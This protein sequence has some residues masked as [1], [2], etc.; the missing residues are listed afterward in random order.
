MRKIGFVLALL[1]AFSMTVVPVVPS[2]AAQPEQK[3]TEQKM[4]SHAKRGDIVVLSQEQMASLATSH[5]A[6]HSKLSEAN[7]KGTLPKLTAAER[8]LVKS[9]T[10]KNMDNLKAGWAAGAWV[11]VAVLAA[12]LWHWH[13]PKCAAPATGWWWHHHWHCPAPVVKAKG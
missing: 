4:I 6:L 13:G 9:M 1:S 2:F 12:V 3:T 10:A 7:Q 8:Q 5:P 11:F